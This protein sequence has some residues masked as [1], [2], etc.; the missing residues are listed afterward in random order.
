MFYL[1]LIVIGA[2]LGIAVRKKKSLLRPLSS[3]TFF[4]L[5]C[6]IFLMGSEVDTAAINP[7][8]LWRALGLCIATIVGSVVCL[9]LVH[10]FLT[11]YYG[12]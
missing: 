6:V 10:S 7:G 1:A 4:L 12:R 5:L 11:H 2:I 8:L 9:A 3:V